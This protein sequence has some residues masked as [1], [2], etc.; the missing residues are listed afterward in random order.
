MLK[1]YYS[2]RERE[3]C[4]EKSKYYISFVALLAIAIGVIA[5]V[6]GTTSKPKT[7][8]TIEQV[9]NILEEQNFKPIDITQLYKEDWGE[10][11]HI[12]NQAVGVDLD[13]IHFEFFVFDSDES[14]EYVRGYYRTY[15]YNQ[16]IRWKHPISLGIFRL[17]K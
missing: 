7:P 6:F 5:I 13:D 14:A 12:L 9:W 11:G 16:H 15:V 10:N 4:A 8:A 3:S 2:I 17:Q 1:Y